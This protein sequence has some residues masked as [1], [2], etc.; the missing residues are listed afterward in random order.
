MRAIQ[1][2]LGD[3]EDR[4]SEVEEYRRKAEEAHLPDY[5]MERVEQELKRLEK[6]PAMVAEAMVITNYLDTLLALPWDKKS[7]EN[8]DIVKAEKILE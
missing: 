7:E 8:L 6:M 5:A 1:T 3:G 2:E 4:S